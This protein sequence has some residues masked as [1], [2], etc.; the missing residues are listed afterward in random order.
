M[1]WNSWWILSSEDRYFVKGVWKNSPPKVQ[2]HPFYSHE[3][4]RKLDKAVNPSFRGKTR[5]QHCPTPRQ[6]L[7]AKSTLVLVFYAISNRGCKEVQPWRQV[8]HWERNDLWWRRDPNPLSAVTNGN[9]CST[10]A[11]YNGTNW[12]A[13]NDC[14]SAEGKENSRQLGQRMQTW[15]HQR[16]FS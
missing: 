6:T 16:T 15:A 8:S 1:S 12:N 2:S 11:L 3:A 4:K 5:R 14:V 7:Y 13:D 9:K 10:V